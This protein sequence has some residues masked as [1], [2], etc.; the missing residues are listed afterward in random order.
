[1]SKRQVNGLMA[2]GGR[3]GESKW[4][5]LQAAE[6]VLK[7][8]I[9][10]AGAKYGFTHGLAGLCKTLGDTGLNFNADAQMAAIQ[11]KPGIRYGEDAQKRDEFM[12]RAKA[13]L[14]R[15]V[16][17][18]EQ[19]DFQA[20][21]NELVPAAPD[22]L[23]DHLGAPERGLGDGFIPNARVIGSL[24]KFRARTPRWSIEIDRGAIRRRNHLRSR[25]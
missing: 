1:M 11:C 21:A 3:Y 25:E 6:K 7:A 23:T 24:V 17:D 14:D 13:I 5:S 20:M 15:N 19:L 16:K 4:A 18:N 22:S 10:R 2:R 8:A 12:V 9:D